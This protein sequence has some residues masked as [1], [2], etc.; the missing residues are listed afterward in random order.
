MDDGHVSYN[1]NLEKEKNTS[2]IEIPFV[3]TRDEEV[4]AKQKYVVNVSS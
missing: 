4:K 3:F 2:I 1:T